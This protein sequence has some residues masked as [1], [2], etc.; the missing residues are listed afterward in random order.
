[1]GEKGAR[2]KSEE[3]RIRSILT[4]RRKERKVRKEDYFFY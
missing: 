3:F 4:Q 1:M 2:I